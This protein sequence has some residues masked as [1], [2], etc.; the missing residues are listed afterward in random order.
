LFYKKYFTYL[1]RGKRKMEKNYDST[2][3]IIILLKICSWV[4]GIISITIGVYLDN[5]YNG[6]YTIIS[7]FVVG[8]VLV[9]SFYAKAES[10]KLSKDI[11]ENSETIIK[12]LD[13]KD[14]TAEG[15]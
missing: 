6:N 12:L 2:Q 9:V 14:K 15:E 1:K 4:A 7:G 11:K 8:C 5:A 13:D 10:L 3:I